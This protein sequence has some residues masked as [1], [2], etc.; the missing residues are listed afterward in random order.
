MKIGSFSQSINRN[1]FFNCTLQE[2]FKIIDNLI[3][4][5]KNAYTNISSFCNYASG[6]ITGAN[7]I[8]SPRGAQFTEILMGRMR[9]RRSS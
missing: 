8:E 5:G 9:Y 6:T 2:N 7:G 4:I 1:K 3:R